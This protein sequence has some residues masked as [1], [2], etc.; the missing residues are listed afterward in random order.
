[1]PPTRMVGSSFPWVS[2][3]PVR[4]VVVVFPWVPATTTDRAPHRN[5]SRMIS[6]S[7]QYRTFRSSTAS[8]SGF[9]RE[10]AL[11]TTTRSRSEV[12]L[13]A[14][15]P[16]NVRIP[17]AARKSLIGGYTFWSDPRTSWPRLRSSAATVAIAVPQTPI[18]WIRFMVMPRVTI[19]GNRRF[20]D[21]QRRMRAGGDAYAH[22]ERQRPARSR[23]VARRKAEDDWPG[24]IPGET[25]NHVARREVATRL[26]AAAHLAEHQRHGARQD[27]AEHQLR[28]HPIEP[29]RAFVDVLEKQDAARRRIECVRRAERRYELRERPAKQPSR[30]LASP[31]HQQAVGRHREAATAL[32]QRHE[33]ALVVSRRAARQ[34]PFDHRTVERGHAALAGEKGQERGVVAVSDEQLG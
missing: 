17:S 6:G 1:M 10:I 31:Q 2:S 24:K 18:R 25:L 34:P 26:L 13:S 22:P 9:P 11:P 7:E 33:R 8:S 19:S 4:D 29:V 32:Q 27:A 3:H 30:R 28:Q 23:R 5:C 21:D 16:V 12:M 14:E 20:L 15:Y